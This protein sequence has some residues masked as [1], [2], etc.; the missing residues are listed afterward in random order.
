V[1]K[2]KRLKVCFLCLGNEGLL[3][4]QRIRPLGT[5]GDLSKYFRRKYLK[6]IKG[7]EGLSCNLCKVPLVNKMHLQQYA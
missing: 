6:Y 3:L 7:R 1:F 4:A 5:L 2:E